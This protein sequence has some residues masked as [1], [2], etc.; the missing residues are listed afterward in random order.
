MEV[1]KNRNLM[2][3][4]AFAKLCKVTPRT[5]KY[6]EEMGILF[7]HT[8]QE[9]GY[10]LY[11]ITQADDLSC[12]LL[13]QEYGFSLK[14]IRELM[15]RHDFNAIFK[16]LALQKEIISQ[17]KQ[18]LLRQEQLVDDTL[19]HMRK[20]QE[21]PDTVFEEQHAPQTI[22]C[23]PFKDCRT[24]HIVQN[25]LLD[26]YRNGVYYSM[27]SFQMLG[28][29]QTLPEGNLLLEGNSLC[30]YHR[31]TPSTGSQYLAM[32]KENA[33]KRAF[34]ANIIFCEAVLEDSQPENCLFR[35]FLIAGV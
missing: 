13:F 30:C 9:N 25:Y 8:V 16:R 26:G 10:R 11:D 17:K 32:L 34:S 5:I 31:G 6:Y 12:I 1:K 4:S 19:A 7:P 24:H 15:S 21:Y 22:V 14:E 33:L 3:V 20:A 29:Y 27:D 28:T 2:T 23:N 35:Y 18:E